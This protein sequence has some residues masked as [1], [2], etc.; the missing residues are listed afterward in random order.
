MLIDVDIDKPKIIGLWWRLTHFILTYIEN[1]LVIQEVFTIKH[2]LYTLNKLNR[3]DSA[4]AL[5]NSTLATKLNFRRIFIISISSDRLY[6][7]PAKTCQ[8]YLY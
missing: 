7:R 6:H 5:F 2:W 4:I 3:L 8:Y 1:V